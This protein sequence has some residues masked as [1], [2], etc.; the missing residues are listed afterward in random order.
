MPSR[1][2]IVIIVKALR[3]V[4]KLINCS[5]L[6][7]TRRI[8]NALYNAELRKAIAKSETRDW[9]GLRKE[10]IASLAKYPGERELME[11]K[12]IIESSSL[13]NRCIFYCADNLVLF[14]PNYKTKLS[15]DLIPVVE[16]VAWRNT[17]HL[18]L[19]LRHPLS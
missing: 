7:E 13:T 6:Q 17:F 14:F 15:Q 2:H 1:F 16:K 5:L 11:T 8:L 4:K 18:T 10:V 19:P 9:I 3:F 12:R